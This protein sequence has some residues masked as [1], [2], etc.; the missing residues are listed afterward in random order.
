[1]CWKG[2]NISA[3]RL[4]DNRRL[5]RMYFV[6]LSCCLPLPFPFFFPLWSIHW[7]EAT[8][9]SGVAKGRTSAIKT[10]CCITAWGR[11]VGRR[12]RSKEPKPWNLLNKS[13]AWMQLKRSATLLWNNARRDW[14][15][16]PSLWGSLQQKSPSG[17]WAAVQG[18]CSSCWVQFWAHSHQ[19]S[20]CSKMDSLFLLFTAN[21]RLRWC[22]R[23]QQ[24]TVA[25]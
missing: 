1:M 22:G 23:G 16:S 10:S 7:T 5:A 18:S 24:R 8:G 14:G 20:H 19:I 17:I 25:G 15:K 13:L 3:A 9:G 4:K 21:C 6:C 11:E 12:W 2:L